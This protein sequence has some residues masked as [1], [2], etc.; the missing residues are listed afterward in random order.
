MTKIL[1]YLILRLPQY[2][3]TLRA[4]LKRRFS[5]DVLEKLLKYRGI[6]RMPWEEVDS[7]FYA[8]SLPKGDG[9]IWAN[10][11][12]ERKGQFGGFVCRTRKEAE[13]LLAFS[14]SKQ[15]INELCVFYSEK[16]AAIRGSIEI[17]ENI[18]WLG[19]DVFSIDNWSL[20]ASGVL[21]SPEFL[22]QWESD[23]NENLLLNS[24]DNVSNLINDYKKFAKS[25]QFVE[26]LIEE[27]LGIDAFKIGIVK[28]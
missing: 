13:T 1:G 5:E 12:K 21:C 25:D 2:N 23:L 20:I 16:I 22:R 15:H 10:M 4:M 28:L 7:A 8:K 26:D 17:E 9:E 6:D 24:A 14:N 19:Y 27:P 18:E 3:D 11:Q